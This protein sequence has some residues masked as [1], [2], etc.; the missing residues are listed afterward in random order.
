ML[1][2]RS[3]SHFSFGL[4]PWQEQLTLTYRETS[5]T[6]EEAFGSALVPL[7]GFLGLCLSVLLWGRIYPM[8]LGIRFKL[9]WLLC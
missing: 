5:G 1:R 4:H 3:H 8:F 9:F 2:D 6:H 7:I